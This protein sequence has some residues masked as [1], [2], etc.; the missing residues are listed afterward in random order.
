LSDYLKEHNN[1][2]YKIKLGIIKFLEKF[3]DKAAID[4]LFA[5]VNDFHRIVQ[6]SAQNAIKSISERLEEPQN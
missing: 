1:E 3:G 2:C 5:N 6:I 4:A